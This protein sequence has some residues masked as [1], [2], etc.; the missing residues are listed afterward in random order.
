MMNHWL[1]IKKRPSTNSRFLA[2]AILIEDRW[3]KSGLLKDIQD[4]FVRST[5]AIMLEGQ[6][7]MNEKDEI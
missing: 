3:R 4:R 2:E 1:K 5:C 6:R 7:L